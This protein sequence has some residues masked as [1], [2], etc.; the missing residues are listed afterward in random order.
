MSVKLKEMADKI[1]DL[2]MSFESDKKYS[3]DGSSI[4][5][6]IYSKN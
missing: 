5:E 4:P 2:G 1:E 6:F 3:K